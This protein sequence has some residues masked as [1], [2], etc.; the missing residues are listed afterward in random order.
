MIGYKPILF[1]LSYRAFILVDSYP[2]QNISVLLIMPGEVLTTISPNTNEPIITRYGPTEEEL[3]Q[4]P[5]VAVEAFNSFRHTP[6]KDR[7]AIVKRALELILE[8]QDDLALELTTQMGR[9]IA[10][11]AKEVTTAVKRAEFLLKISDEALSNTDGEAELGFK[12]YIKKVPV[13]PVLIIFAWNVSLSHAEL[14]EGIM[15]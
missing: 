10:Y 2:S 1:V 13:G 15:R 7:Q 12:R 6:L 9:P 14:V 3:K 8:K 11:T 5:E 4:L